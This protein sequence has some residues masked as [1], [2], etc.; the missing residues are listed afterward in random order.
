MMR[1]T[2][3]MD[4]SEVRRIVKRV[5]REEP[6][7]TPSGVLQAARD[8]VQTMCEEAA[9]YGLTP[10]D[11]VKGVLRPVFEAYEKKRGCNCP[12]CRARRNDSA[13]EQPLQARVQVA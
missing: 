2:E 7:P 4:I 10:A 8:A 3:M 13:E 5:V 11:I 9:Q 6:T 12:T 1:Q